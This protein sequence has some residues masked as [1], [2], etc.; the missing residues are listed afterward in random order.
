MDVIEAIKTRHSVRA[1]LD[2][3]V[4]EALVREIIEISKQSPL[5]LTHSLGR[6]MWL[7]GKPKTL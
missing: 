6:Y 2:K 3:P 5:E 4:E 1:Y 7:W